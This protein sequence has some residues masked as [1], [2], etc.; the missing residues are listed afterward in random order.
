MDGLLAHGSIG[1]GEFL[2][3]LVTPKISASFLVLEF[4]LLRVPRLGCRARE[5]PKE[6]GKL[7]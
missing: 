5:H 1:V 7:G 4:P 2:E 6:V 3:C